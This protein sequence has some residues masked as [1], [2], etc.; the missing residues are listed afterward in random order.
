MI[1]K[2]NPKKIR[3]SWQPT[4]LVSN[5]VIP[6]LGYMDGV[7]VEVEFDEDQ[8]TTHV[9]ADGT[10]SFI[11]NANVLAKATVTIVQGSPTN[12]QL[13]ANVPSAAK[14]SIPS[15]P[16]Q[17]SDL[18][19]TSYCHADDAVLA[20]VPKVTFSN[21]LEGRQWLFYLPQA[22]IVPGGSQL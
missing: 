2:Y 7:F 10:V 19:G 15:G 12:D 16:F 11:L 17:M 4:N 5:A 20:K 1:L 22:T 14:N 9:G 13:I 8:V 3:T 18:N 6:F 21:K